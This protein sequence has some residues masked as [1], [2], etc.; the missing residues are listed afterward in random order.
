MVLR[1]FCATLGLLLGALESFFGGSWAPLGCSWGSLGSF[2]GTK[3]PFWAPLAALLTPS[4]AH[5]FFSDVIVLLFDL[6]GV[7]FGLPR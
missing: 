5:I 2:S 4:V 3:R 7:D 6:L 1:V